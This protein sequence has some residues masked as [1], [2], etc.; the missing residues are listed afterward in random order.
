VRDV[1]SDE[2]T[3]SSA[4]FAVEVAVEALPLGGRRLGAVGVKDQRTKD[5]ARFLSNVANAVPV[6]AQ[7]LRELFATGVAGEAEDHLCLERSQCSEGGHEY[8]PDEG[9]L[10]LVVACRLSTDRLA[11]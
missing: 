8:G 7:L 6:N 1:A 10:G 4:E 3:L 11:D 5:I 2:P 9:L